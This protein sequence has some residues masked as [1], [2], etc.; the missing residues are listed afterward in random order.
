MKYDDRRSSYQEDE[1]PETRHEEIHQRH[2][3]WALENMPDEHP[4]FV[5]VSLER[6]K[7][8]G[9]KPTVGKIREHLEALG[10]DRVSIDERAARYER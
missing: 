3:A 1:E 9:H 2:L 8:G 4:P 7:L 6:L 10:R 5:A